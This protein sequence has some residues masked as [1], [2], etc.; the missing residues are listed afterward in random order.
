MSI[1]KKKLQS[2]LNLSTKIHRVNYIDFRNSQTHLNLKSLSEIF[3]D[4]ERINDPATDK[5]INDLSV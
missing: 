2:K 4:L 3:I 1:R 5:K